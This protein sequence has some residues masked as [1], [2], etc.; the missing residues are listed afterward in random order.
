MIRPFVLLAALALPALAFA[1]EVPVRE[2][3]L[4]AI[5]GG[6]YLLRA[7]APHG[8]AV[9][10]NRDRGHSTLRADRHPGLDR[11]AY[12]AALSERRFDYGLAQRI[13]FPFPVIGNSS[14]ALTSGPAWRSQSR[15]AATRPGVAL[16]VARLYERDHLYVYPSHH[17]YR[18]DDLFPA[19]MPQVL[20]SLGSSGSDRPLLEGLFAALAALPP[21][22]YALLR[23]ERMLAPTLS[24][25]LRRNLAGV[26]SDADYLSDRAHGPVIDGARV[27]A[28]AM[29]AHAARMTP[30]RSPPDARIRVL[31]EDFADAAGLAGESERLFVTAHSVARVWRGFDHGR[32]IVLTAADSRDATG[33]A[34]RYHWVLLQ[35]DPARVS[36]AA[37]GA[38]ARI[39]IA[40]HAPFPLPDGRMS[41]RVDV[42]LFADNGA[43][44]S[45]PAILSVSFPAYQQRLYAPDG[46]GAMRLT[47]IGY[48][49][50]AY[51]DPL[52][53]WRAPWT[54][55]PL[56]GPDGEIIA[57]TRHWP[58][59][60]TTR[61]SAGPEGPDYRI[62]RTERVPR[63]VEE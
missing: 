51:I 47:E 43:E 2:G 33:R 23:R 17:D 10:D 32:D 8:R 1:G 39:R 3:D 22:T 63:L 57:W 28:D 6:Q 58:D 7:E 46:A 16:R 53:H 12:D 38:E 41:S 25:I 44:I 52:L 35:G 11:T 19:N 13:V 60:R 40:W 26:E 49:G 48:D 36:I 5:P 24:M 50:D 9:Y 54:D 37:D 45:A 42:A 31:E 15:L 20:T 4:V 21:E 62:D 56:R 61:V 14:T 30:D 29:A 34:L 18:G 27:R 55:T 59:G